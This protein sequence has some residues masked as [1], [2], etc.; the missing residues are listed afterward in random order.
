M[1]SPDR[2]WTPKNIKIQQKIARKRQI[3]QHKQ[4]QKYREKLYLEL[5]DEWIQIEKIVI[6]YR[7][8]RERLLSRRRRCH[9]RRATRGRTSPNSN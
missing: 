7:M 1:C 9:R 5:I 6:R 3:R 2:F 4:L 8:R